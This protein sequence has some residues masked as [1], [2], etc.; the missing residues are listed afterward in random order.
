MWD[1]YTG[2][3]LKRISGHTKFVNCSSANRTGPHILLTGSDDCKAKV[4]F[5]LFASLSL[6]IN[7][8]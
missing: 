1:T 6:F 4:L 5:I 7:Y 8:F 2:E 3:L